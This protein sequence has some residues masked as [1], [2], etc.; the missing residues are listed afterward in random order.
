V[1]HPAICGTPA[2][3]TKLVILSEAKNLGNAHTSL[4][5]RFFLPSVVRMTAEGHSL[6]PVTGSP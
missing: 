2:I 6:N 5:P 4:L 1:G 3:F